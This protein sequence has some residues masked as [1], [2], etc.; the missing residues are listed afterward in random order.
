MR[1]LTA[2]GFGVAVALLGVCTIGAPARA[3]SEQQNLID[4]A[5]VTIQAARHDPQF[6]TSA[7]LLR[8]AKAVLVVPQ[9]VKGGFFVGGEGGTGVLLARHANGTWGPPAFYVLASASFGLQIG[10]EESE[11]MMFIMTD[12]AL[13]ALEKNEVKLGAQAGLTLLVIGS[14][15]QAASATNAHVDIIVWSKSKGAYGGITLE[16]SV[17]KPRTEWNTAY[18]GHPVNSAAL[19]NG[20]TESNPSAQPLRDSLAR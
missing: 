1:K 7:E 18:Y 12:S 3:A 17:I 6:G 14:S 15:A 13:H 19:I 5:Q 8:R 20:T 10:L 2:L 4:R 11:V 9:L 16:G